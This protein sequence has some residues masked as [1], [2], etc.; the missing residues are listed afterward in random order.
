MIEIVIPEE[1]EQD[2]QSSRKI[3]EAPGRMG[4][5]GPSPVYAVPEKR[6]RRMVRMAQRFLHSKNPESHLI[7]IVLQEML[8]YFG[9]WPERK[10][11]E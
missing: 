1:K 9:F 3:A 8:S 10:D 2:N 6:V 4:T 5:D 11:M 7:G